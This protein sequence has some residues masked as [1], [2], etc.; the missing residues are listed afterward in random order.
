MENRTWLDSSTGWNWFIWSLCVSWR[1]WLHFSVVDPHW[2]D[3]CVAVENG[4]L[5]VSGP[6]ITG[7]CVVAS[8]S[9]W[10]LSGDRNWLDFGYV[11]EV[12]LILMFGF[13]IDWVWASGSNLTCFWCGCQ[14]RL[15]FGAQS[16]NH[17]VL[18]F[19][20]KLTRCWTWGSRL[21]WFWDA[22]GK[23]LL[24]TPLFMGAESYEKSESLQ[25]FFA[26]FLMYALYGSKKLRKKFG[27]FHFR[28]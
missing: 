19:G 4:L 15:R 13:E 5:L 8:K 24:L 7:F 25:T 10:Y 3:F 28:Q 21:T 17:L 26:T 6:K 12:S 16:E 14:N 11:V 23:W 20:S 2:F 27:N 18:I 22:G 1:K 9:S